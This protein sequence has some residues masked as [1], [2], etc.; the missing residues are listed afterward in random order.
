M[1]GCFSGKIRP[2]DIDGV[3]ERRGHFLILE[4]KPCGYVFRGGQSILYEALAALPKFTILIL[5]GKGQAV[6]TMQEWGKEETSCTWENVCVF[7]RKWFQNAN[8]S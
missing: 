3:V 5:R 6:S 8:S 7:C 2:S 4:K 1:E